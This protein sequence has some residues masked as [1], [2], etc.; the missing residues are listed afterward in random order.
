MSRIVTLTISDNYVI[1]WGIW[2]AIRELAQ[3]AMDNFDKTGNPMSIGFHKRTKN[4]IVQSKNTKL[5]ISSLILGNGDKQQDAK[6]RG[7]FGEGYKLALIVLLRLGIKITIQNA[8]EVWVPNFFYNSEFNANL[9]TISIIEKQTKNKDLTFV[10]TGIDNMMANKFKHRLIT[11]NL[12]PAGYDTDYGKI[13]TEER[14]RGQVFVGGI[15]VCKPNI[16]LDHGF[17][18]KPEY[19]ELGRDRGLIDSFTV[20]WLASCMWTSIKNIDDAALEATADLVMKGERSTYYIGTSSNND[21]LT[22]RVA[23]RFYSQ[24]PETAVPVATEKAR[25]EVLNRYDNAVP[26]IVNETVERVVKHSKKYSSVVYNLKEKLR[27]TPTEVIIQVLSNFKLELGPLHS[28]LS[29]E[30]VPVSLR[31]KLDDAFKEE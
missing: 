15:F 8:D 25:Q 19:V 5:D 10:L 1:D 27:L 2:E 20:Q 12:S 13:L 16:E 26:I 23:D 11:S 4:F 28:K 30:L 21:E 24:A 17:D 22:E 18:F 3:N 29:N 6:C 31:W 9:L 14:F 7:K